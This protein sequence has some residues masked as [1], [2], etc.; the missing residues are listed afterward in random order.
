MKRITN[1]QLAK[2]RKMA[3]A[4]RKIL[5]VLYRVKPEKREAVIKSAALLHGI[6][7]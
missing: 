3:D 5:G 7:I 6:E 1:E 2:A 4:E